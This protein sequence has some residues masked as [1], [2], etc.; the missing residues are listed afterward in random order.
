MRDKICLEKSGS[1]IVQ[2]V[3]V[4]TGTLRLIAAEGADR[5]RVAIQHASHM[6]MWLGVGVETHSAFVVDVK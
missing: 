6:G 2:A 5:R 4:R 3:N 1:R